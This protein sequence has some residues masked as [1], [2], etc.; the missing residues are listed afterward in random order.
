MNI[1]KLHLMSNSRVSRHRFVVE[2]MFSFALF[3]FERFDGLELYYGCYRNNFMCT[4]LTDCF[5]ATLQGSPAILSVP[6][7]QSC[8]R[9]EMLL[10]TVDTHTGMLQCHVPQYDTPLMTELQAAFNGDHSRLPAL[11]SELRFGIFIRIVYKLIVYLYRIF[12]RIVYKL[13]V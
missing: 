1:I 6:V 7:L 10:I 13:I 2:L 4:L 8:L 3:D 12:I 9:A 5:T 11:L